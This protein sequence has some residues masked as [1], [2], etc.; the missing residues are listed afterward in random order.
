VGAR[1]GRGEYRGP[2]E[3]LPRVEATTILRQA[4]KEEKQ[5]YW[6]MAYSRDVTGSEKKIVI[7][8]RYT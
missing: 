4:A 1:P 3:G 6:E 7:D 5:H 2:R 8:N